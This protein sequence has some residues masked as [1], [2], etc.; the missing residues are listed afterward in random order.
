MQYKFN[1]WQDLFS[2]IEKKDY[3]SE[4]K[5]FV[6][7]EY[8]EFICYPPKELIFNAFKQCN[9]DDL[10][11]VIIGQDPYHEP[12]QAMGLCFSVPEGVKIPPSLKNII[13]EIEDEYNVVN[14]TN[15]GDLTYLANQGCLLLNALLTVREHEPMSHNIKQY[16]LFLKD[17]LQYINN[18]DRPIVF[19]LW[20][21]P[22]RKLKKFLNNPNHLILEANHPSPLSANR[23]GWFGCNHFKIAN[24]FL[25][26]NNGETI[27]WL[28]KY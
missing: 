7:K 1:S 6:E 9:K 16:S 21:G 19:M 2:S 28:E 13:R 20:G 17:V 23:G 15:S 8:N 18:I 10:K 11:V 26:E 22:A 27:E 25:L 14:F 3:F 4:I 5:T 24:K 12:N